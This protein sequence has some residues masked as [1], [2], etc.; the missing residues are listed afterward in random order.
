MSHRTVLPC[1]LAALALTPAAAQA[2]YVT[3]QGAPG[4]G[5]AKYA[6]V[7]IDKV[8]P[9]KPKRVL[10]LIPGTFAGSGSFRGV[11]EELVKD[12]KGLAVWSIDRRSNV[13]ED[14]SYMLKA[15]RGEVTGQQLFDYYL[16][17]IGKDPEPAEHYR[18]LKDEDFTFARG[19]GLRTAMEDTRRVIL[20]ARKTGATV[21]LGGHSLGAS[22]VYDYAA[23]DFAG[24]AGYR[25][26]AG[27]VAIDGGGMRDSADAAEVQAAIDE[28]DAGSPW[29]DLLKLGLPWTSGVFQETGAIGVL[30]DPDAPSI[31]QASPLLPAQF[32]P[33]V[34]VTNEGLF[35]YAFDYRT[36]PE[37][38]AL[39]HVHSGQI[40]RTGAEPYGWKNDGI[41]PIER[42]ARLAATEPG[43]FVEWYYPRR[44]TIDV[45]AAASLKRDAANDAA[46]NRV[47]H[48]KQVN[49][50]LY[51]FQT[52]LSDGRVIAGAKAFAGVSKVPSVKLVNR[53]K[54]YAHLDPLTAA[55][56]RNDFLKTVVPFLR[57]I[58]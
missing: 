43:N 22:S 51:A 38:L 17:W 3:I 29:L 10:V 28:N 13:L 35:G 15:K 6:R 19:W 41:T 30:V 14:T 4:Y 42:L 40:D 20:A 54:T 31:G 58:R 18:P 52:S 2:K 44:L 57:R 55:P 8:G 25:D 34:P 48:A 9:K 49:V 56:K 1:L 24:R 32:K 23:W 36:S 45:G 33:D 50:P 47:W 46:G 26:I 21:I 11:A 53:E 37:A 16:G 12:V 39:I 7:G 5:P 27:M